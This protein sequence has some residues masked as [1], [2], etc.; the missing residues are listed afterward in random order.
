M[1]RSVNCLD[2]R[3]GANPTNQL[4]IDAEDSIGWHFYCML[5]AVTDTDI[6]L[7]H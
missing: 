6:H 7:G 1:N 4:F 5:T 3:V 2:C